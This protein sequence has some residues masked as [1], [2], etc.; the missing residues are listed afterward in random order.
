MQLAEGLGPVHDSSER[1][2]GS[3][4][5][6]MLRGLHDLLL[7]L[8]VSGGGI[9]PYRVSYVTEKITKHFSGDLYKIIAQFKWASVVHEA[10]S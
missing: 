6:A 2:A 7:S 4:R 5:Y 9:H 8:V 10:G 1:R 3:H